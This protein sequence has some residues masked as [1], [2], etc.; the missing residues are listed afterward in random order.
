MA[1]PKI[2]ADE[3]KLSNENLQAGFLS[4]ITKKKRAN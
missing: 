1:Y 4:L 2:A 3:Y